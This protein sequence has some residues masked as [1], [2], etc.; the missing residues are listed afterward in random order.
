MFAYPC[1]SCR[2]RLLAPPNRVGQR[3]ICPKCLHPLTVPHPEQ[4]AAAAGPFAPAP[5]PPTPE[6]P[7]ELSVGDHAD[8]VSEH[9]TPAP[10]NTLSS[11]AD[12]P[13]SEL[14]DTTEPYLDL[15]PVAAEPAVPPVIDP[16]PL[17]LTPDPAPTAKPTPPAPHP[18]PPTPARPQPPKRKREQDGRI[19]FDPAGR[20]AG[21]AIAQLSAA[22]SMRMAPPPPVADA[23]YATFGLGAG[24]LVGLGL[25]VMGVWQSAEW[26]P[27]TALVGGAMVAFGL[28]WRAY[29][30]SVGGS[31]V[32]GAVTLLPPV[33]LVQLV[34]PVLGYGLRPLWFVLAG[35]ALI[36]LF[37]VG[38]P[39]KRWVDEQ[40]DV[41]TGVTVGRE[42]K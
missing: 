33:C 29:L 22:L 34:R 26:L 12:F 30:S 31:W 17:S 1:P 25:W 23:A 11:A 14:A 18:A 40:I 42:G 36:G 20:F 24:T 7:F 27:Y 10:M 15:T 37:A 6:E 3:S 8:G 13:G 21:D 35:A 39:A 16:I 38:Q 9:D 19:A 4:L 41:K 2:Q 5:A 32:N 28:L